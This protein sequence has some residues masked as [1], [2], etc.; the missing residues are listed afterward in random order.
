M[1]DDGVRPERPLPAVVEGAPESTDG[2]VVSD[3]GA[4]EG[5]TGEGRT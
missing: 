3:C 5:V 4:R 2:G 1:A